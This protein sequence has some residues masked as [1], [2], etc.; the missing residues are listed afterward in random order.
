MFLFLRSGNKKIL[1]SYHHISC[2]S[3]AFDASVTAVG[4]AAAVH[5][6]ATAA[7]VVDADAELDARTS[8]AYVCCG[9]YNS[10]GVEICMWHILGLDVAHARCMCHKVCTF[11]RGEWENSI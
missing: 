3:V 6:V 8:T 7:H 10:P 1:L 11:S 4:G 9:R 5:V 2:K